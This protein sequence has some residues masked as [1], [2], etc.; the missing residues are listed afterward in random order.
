MVCAEAIEG[1]AHRAAMSTALSPRAHCER[2]NIP[3]LLPKNDLM[4][5]RGS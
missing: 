4:R 2:S 5:Y 3:V 1:T